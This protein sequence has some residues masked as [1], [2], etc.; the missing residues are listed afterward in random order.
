MR[1][2]FLITDYK[3]QFGSKQR[4]EFYMSGFNKKLLS[5][6]FE[7]LGYDAEYIEFTDVDFRAGDFN[8]QLV[9]YTSS[10]DPGLHYKNYIEDIIYGLHLHGAILLP[11]YKYLR[12]TNNKVFMEI[13]RDLSNLTEIKNIRTRTFGT[14]AELERRAEDGS[15]VIKPS[16]GAMSRGVLL[17]KNKNELIRKAKK[18]S[19]TRFLYSELWDL[20]NKIKHRKY[21]PHSLYR[22]KFIVQNFVQPLDNDWK[23]LVYG[24]KYYALNRKTRK[25]DFRASGS[26]LFHYSKELPEG[27]LDFARIIYKAMNVP[28]LSMDI[29]YDGREYYLLEFQAVYFG[30]KTL[31]F[32]EF[33][34]QGSNSSWKTI[35]GKSELEKVYAESIDHYIRENKL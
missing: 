26:G 8:N 22:S 33:Y 11:E 13:L 12:A 9:N 20:K 23:V 34:F 27:L 32:A 1:K 2:I 18:I 17:S 31:E 28:Q 19:R 6:R 14:V 21:I 5:Q 25:N 4:A 7:D 3:K 29:A 16:A 35:N 24:D 30:T 10:E 15:F